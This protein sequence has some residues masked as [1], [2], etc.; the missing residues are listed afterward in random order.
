MAAAIEAL[1]L[2]R[3]SPSVRKI[4]LSLFTALEIEKKLDEAEM[5]LFLNEP[6]TTAPKGW[7]S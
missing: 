3:L 2:P 6:P 4:M 1:A 5:L 7:I